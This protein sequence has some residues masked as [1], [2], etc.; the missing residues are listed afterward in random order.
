M[1]KVIV[2]TVFIIYL[3]GCKPSQQTANIS[4]VLPDKSFLC[5][6]SQSQCKINTELGSFTVLFSGQHLAGKIR[7]ELP[8]TI[9]LRMESEQQINR[10]TKVS[11]YLEGKTMFM[12]KVPV[13]FEA[14]E[15]ANI[16]LAE[17][18]LARCSHNVMT[19]QLRLQIEVTTENKTLEQSFFIDFDTENS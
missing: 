9:Q 4:T 8:F 17:A 16:L 11:S 14:T 12:G 5:L 2:V 18:L 19:W 6:E 3:F 7:T 10:I 13:F 1:Y 15:N